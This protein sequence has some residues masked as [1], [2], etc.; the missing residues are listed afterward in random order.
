M[1]SFYRAGPFSPRAEWPRV[2]VVVCVYN[3]EETI[4]ECLAGLERLAY[5]D[6]EVIVV[7]DGSTDRTAQIAAGHRCK[8]IQTTNHGLSS[9]RNT[10]IAAADGE[11]VAF[12]DADA[13]PDPHWL[14]YTVE[15][16]RQGGYVGVGGPNPACPGDGL[17]A[18]CVSQAP[19]GPTHVLLSDRVAEHIPGVNMTFRRAA[20]QEIGGF[21]TRFRV[22]GDDVDL[23]WRLQERGWKLGFS[24]AA[25]VWH[26][27]RRTLRGY[28]RQQRGYG[29]A[30]ALLEEKWPQKYNA[31]GQV[32]WSGRIYA[33]LLYSLRSTSRIYHGTWGTAPFQPRHHEFGRLSALAAAPDWYLVVG[34]LA[35]LSLLAVAWRPLLVALPLLVLALCLSFSHAVLGA[36]GA[37]FPSLAPT[38]G[39][40]LRRRVTTG[41]LFLFQPWARLAGRLSAGLT[42]WRS[43]RPI[44]LGVPWPRQVSMWSERWRDTPAW[45]ESLERELMS[46]GAVVRR[47]GPYDR[48]D[49]QVRDGARGV[50]RLRMCVE[51]HGGGRQLLRFR[52]WPWVR[53]GNLIWWL[54]VG[55]TALALLAAADG[56]Q[57]AAALLGAVGVG[58]L[59]D[60]V[61]QTCSAMSLVV[62]KLR[63][64]AGVVPIRARRF[65]SPLTARQPREASGRA[66][67]RRL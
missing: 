33:P 43:R 6:Y 12:I 65:R 23:C 28:G 31:S 47:G 1:S 59:L 52:V 42:P 3:G 16:L 9:A 7:D 5:P 14:H 13:W 53:T 20:L 55:P 44:R 67:T 21:D 15:T 38:L 25:I 8:L 56:A 24:P 58:F 45:L 41:F 17:I 2:S 48:W 60:G 19:G 63:R 40:A 34:A 39:S 22:A 36:A 26:H 62:G 37:R 32:T 46:M 10:G 4:G 35:A 51:D 30:E 29:H 27:Q 54:S 64:V 61:R 11:F 50:V 18:E 49:L 66:R 57:L